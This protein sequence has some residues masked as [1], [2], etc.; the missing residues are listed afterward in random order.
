M[1]RNATWPAEKGGSTN[2]RPGKQMNRN[3]AWPT[4]KGG[5][6][7]R[8]GKQMNRNVASPAEKGRTPTV[9]DLGD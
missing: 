9:T 7:D 3:A 8:P 6:S 4:E 5:R 1:N 2:D